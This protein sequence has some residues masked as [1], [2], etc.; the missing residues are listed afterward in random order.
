V[1]AVGHR[2]RVAHRGMVRVAQ[3]LR[4]ALALVH[5]RLAEHRADATLLEHRADHLGVPHG[6]HVVHARGARGDHLAQ[7]KAR[8]GGDRGLGVRRLEGPDR[9]AQPAQQVALLGAA[10][11][12]H[13]AQVEVGLDEAGQHETAR[14]V[15]RLVGASVGEVPHGV[16]GVGPEGGD[17]AIAHQQ[18]ALGHGAGGVHAHQRPGVYEVGAQPVPP[19]TRARAMPP[20]RRAT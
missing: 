13:L 1:K 9:L 3:A 16:G 4:H 14:G 6:A 5:Q 10:P 2:E 12:Q 19:C 7:A 8:G 15:V 11:E 17:H 20:C 18:R